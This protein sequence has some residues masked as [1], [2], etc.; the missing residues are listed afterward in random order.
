MGKVDNSITMICE[1]SELL[2]NIFGHRFPYN[3]RKS[4][5]AVCKA[6]SLNVSRLQGV[7]IGRLRFFENQGPVFF[8]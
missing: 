4:L 5:K 7:K 3:A 8:G 1:G 2:Q 6:Y